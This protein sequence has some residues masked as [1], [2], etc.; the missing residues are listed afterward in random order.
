MI[1]DLLQQFVL[2]QFLCYYCEPFILVFRC[3][4]I[5][6]SRRKFI[7]LIRCNVITT[8]CTVKPRFTAAIS[9]PPNRTKHTEC[10][11]NKTP[12]YCGPRFTAD[13]SFPPNTAVNRGFTVVRKDVNNE[14]TILTLIWFS[15]SIHFNWKFTQSNGTFRS[16]VDWRWIKRRQ[17]A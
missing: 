9:F 10:K 2:N 1:A 6:M 11:P 3:Y 5:I 13:V 4:V 14:C 17:E 8:D 7:K 15:I 16:Y 12:I